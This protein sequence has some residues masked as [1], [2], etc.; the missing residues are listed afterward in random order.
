MFANYGNVGTGNRRPRTRAS[1]F[2]LRASLALATACVGFLLAASG[3]A[4]AAPAHL[5]AQ[6]GI[7]TTSFWPADMSHY[8]NASQAGALL[9]ALSRRCTDSKLHCAFRRTGKTA[10]AGAVASSIGV[11]VWAYIPSESGD[12]KRVLWDVSLPCAAGGAQQSL[13]RTAVVAGNSYQLHVT[14][15]AA[16]ANVALSGPSNAWFVL[17]SYQLDR[18]GQLLRGQQLVRTVLADAYVDQNLAQPELGGTNAAGNVVTAG[19][20]RWYSQPAGFTYTWLICDDD[21]GSSCSPAPDRA[22]SLYYGIPPDATG[23]VAVIVSAYDATG[24]RI[25]TAFVVEHQPILQLPINAVQPIITGATGIDDTLSISNGTWSNEVDSFSYQWFDCPSLTT[26]SS[27]V[28]VA[29]ATASTYKITNRDIGYY[30]LGNVTAH[31]AAGSTGV[32]EITP[33]KIIRTE[34][35]MSRWPTPPRQTR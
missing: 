11:R 30:V 7:S 35:A 17:D 31:N 6:S 29:K 4:M 26:F 19:T 3:P 33:T 32:D 15:T 34:V 1:R 21:A 24:D 12:P 18:S 27:C 23:Y 14:C 25:G 13:M 8:R 22:D 10:P 28:A 5:S 2:V 16:S 9:R 20:G